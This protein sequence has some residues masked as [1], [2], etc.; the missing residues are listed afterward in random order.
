MEKGAGSQSPLRFCP[1][2][3]QPEDPSRESSG[4]KGP[5]EW[6]AQAEPLGDWDLSS[7]W[8]R[9]SQGIVTKCSLGGLDFGPQAAWMVLIQVQM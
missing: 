3:R 2:R 8:R 9:G 4:G 7:G 1:I 6:S 5:E